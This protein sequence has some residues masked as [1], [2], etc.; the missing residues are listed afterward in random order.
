MGRAPGLPG[1]HVPVGKTDSE[2]VN[3]ML[4]IVQTVLPFIMTMKDIGE[5]VY[6]EWS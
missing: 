2:Q 1:A 6:I 4:S 5:L 3:K